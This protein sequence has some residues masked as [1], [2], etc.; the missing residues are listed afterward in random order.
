MNDFRQYEQPAW[1]STSAETTFSREQSFIRT[2]YAWMF[3]G[4]LLTAL[5]AFFVYA[6]P[7]LRA[8]V[9]QP[10]A[11]IALM[12][13]TFGLVMFLSFRITKIQPG[14]AAGLFLLYSA[15]NG[16]MLSAIFMVY[17]GGTILSAFVVAGGMFGS[18]A[19]Y[20]TLTKKDL[21][22]WGSFFFM[23]LIGIIL[24]QV[25][26][27]FVKS[28]AL[29]GTIALVG[30]FVFVGLT[31]YDAQKLKAYAAAAG[32][33]VTNFAVIGALALYLDFINIFLMLL[34]LFGRRD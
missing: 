17:S 5:S 29:D 33:N 13:A 9:F 21:T 22:S 34:R 18:M 19:A 3:G 32:P 27:M 6:T 26:N 7:A 24:A 31:A 4:L 28:S 10:F 11:A 1:I 8:V 2:T 16:L 25:V 12:V 15:L 30:V 20:G 23:G 14:T